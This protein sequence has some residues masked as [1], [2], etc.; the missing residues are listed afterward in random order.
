[1]GAF[2][3]LPRAIGLQKAKELAF[4]A[5]RV[6]VEEAKALGIVHA[7]HPAATLRDDAIAFARR[8]VD[9]PREAIGLSKSLFNKRFETPYA[10]LAELECQAQAI[11]AAA[12]YHAQ[13]IDRFLRGEPAAFD[14][15]RS[16]AR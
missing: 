7:L 6:G 9:A 15:D 13:A 1:L 10:T 3:M 16:A 8:F 14:W 5:R 4:S 11:A 12:P 2:Y